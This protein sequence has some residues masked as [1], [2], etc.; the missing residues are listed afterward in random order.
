[1]FDPQP[2]HLNYA[3]I[4][5]QPL[6]LAHIEQ[7]QQCGNVDDIWTWMAPNPCKTLQSTQQWIDVY[8]IT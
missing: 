2:I 4:E 8:L 7:F 3:D 5:L 1:M 6:S